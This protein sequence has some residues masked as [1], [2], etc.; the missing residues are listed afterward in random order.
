MFENNEV[1]IFSKEDHFGLI[2]FDRLEEIDLIGS[3]STKDKSKV[4]LPQTNT[5]VADQLYNEA[6]QST[7][8]AGWK[9]VYRGQRNWG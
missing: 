9:L 7:F 5:I 6:I 2:I 3:I 1:N 4:S 8:E